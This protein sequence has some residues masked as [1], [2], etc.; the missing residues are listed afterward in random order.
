MVFL[1]VRQMRDQYLK[2]FLDRLL[3]RLF[4]FVMQYRQIT[5]RCVLCIAVKVVKYA[6]FNYIRGVERDSY[7]VRRQ[8]GQASVANADA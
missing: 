1:S 6:K 4:I 3:S 7:F 2:L 5:R 8:S